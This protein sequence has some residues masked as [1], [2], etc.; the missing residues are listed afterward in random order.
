MAFGELNETTLIGIAAAVPQT[1]AP[2][3][4]GDDEVGRGI[5]AGR[6]MGRRGSGKARRTTLLVR[7]ISPRVFNFFGARWCM[8]FA[9]RE[10]STGD[11]ATDEGRDWGATEQ[12]FA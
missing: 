4:D 3:K 10:V 9:E 6:S 7:K 5:A 8:H 1:Q 2:R 11:E 12:Q